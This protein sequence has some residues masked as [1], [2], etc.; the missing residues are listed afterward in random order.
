LGIFAAKIAEINPGLA[1]AAGIE[2]CKF[3]KMIKPGDVVIC[4]VTVKKIRIG[5]EQSVIVASA[6]VK[7]IGQKEP[8][9]TVDDLKIFI[10]HTRNSKGETIETR[11]GRVKT[12][13]S[14]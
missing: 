1:V 13:N 12:G 3:K 10:D 4:T 6:E 5:S 8:A 9:T 7:V 14:D 2:E 11:N